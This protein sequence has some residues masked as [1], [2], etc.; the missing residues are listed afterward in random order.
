MEQFQVTV[1]LSGGVYNART[2]GSLDA[3]IGEVF[4][5]N[6]RCKFVL[7]PAWTLFR[8]VNRH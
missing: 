7:Y 3:E 8:E 4:W 5:A 1:G 6:R 2:R